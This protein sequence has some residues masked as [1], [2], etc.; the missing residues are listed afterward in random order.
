MLTACDITVCRRTN[1]LVGRSPQ[2]FATV[3]RPGVVAGQSTRIADLGF[4]QYFNPAAF[5]IPGT[6]TSAL[7]APV[8]LF[9]HAGRCSRN[10]DASLFKD[11]RLRE[12]LTMGNAA[13]SKLSDSQTVGRQVQFG[14]KLVW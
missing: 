7:G 11:F 9:D 13:F 8:Q 3:N 1:A 10:P 14:L 12:L 6:V 2:V 5:A 4:D